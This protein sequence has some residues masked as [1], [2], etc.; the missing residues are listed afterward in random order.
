MHL[1]TCHAPATCSTV[2]TAVPRCTCARARSGRA[3]NGAVCRVADDRPRSV[4]IAR[5][6]CALCQIQRHR[7][8]LGN[9]VHVEYAVIGRGNRLAAW[10]DARYMQSCAHDALSRTAHEPGSGSTTHSHAMLQ[11]PVAQSAPLYPAAHVH[12]HDPAVP[13]GVPCVESQT[14]VPTVLPSPAVHGFAAT[15]TRFPI[16][17]RHALLDMRGCSDSQGCTKLGGACS[18]KH[19]SFDACLSHL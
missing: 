9:H 2:R 12:V 13:P 1:F 3:A 11:P 10:H 14:I 5:S 4:A 18:V 15:Q 19:A 17:G 8:A 6:A 7:I 16:Q